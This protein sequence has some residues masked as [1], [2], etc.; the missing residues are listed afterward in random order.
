MLTEHTRRSMITRRK[1]MTDS[2]VVASTLALRRMLRAAQVNTPEQATEPEQNQET[3]L[4]SMRASAAAAPIHDTKLT[5]TISLLQSVGA[6]IVVF[7]GP[8]GK[9]LIDAG[10][11]TGA[12]RL[13]DMLTKL[14]PHPIK[15]LINTS[16]LFDHTDGNAALHLAG[17]FILAQQNTRLRLDAPQKIPMFNLTLPPSPASALPQATFGDRQT[18]YLNNDELDLVYAPDASTDSDTFV[19]FVNTNVIHAGELWY[20][21]G[22]PVID[23][24]SGGTIHGMIRGLERV[25]RLADDRTKIIPSHG[26]AGNKADL[27]AYREMLES[28]AERIEKLR[29]AGQSLD[30]VIASRPTADLDSQ[31]PHGEITP[32]MFLTAV[33]NTL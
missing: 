33:Y 16:W 30:E 14:G 2:A 22:Y 23:T 26:D 19:H 31:W 24:A 13:L 8:D 25:L 18:L 29:A 27:A 11:A 28:V 32:A 21:G 5:D 7:S 9:I 17:A 4:Q 1:F 12:P 10:M 6:N 20:N 3:L 15:L